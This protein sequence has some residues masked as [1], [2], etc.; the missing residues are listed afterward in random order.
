MRVRGIALASTSFLLG[1]LVVIS[2]PATGAGDPSVVHFTA[3]ADYGSLTQTDSVLDLIN[4]TDPDLNIAVG[5]LSYAA[6]G[7][8]QAWSDRVTSRVG[9]GFPFEL[10]SGN[11]ESNGLNGN[12]NDFSACLPNQLPG[13]IGTYGRQYYVDTPQ[14]APLVRFI[15]LDANLDFADGTHS[16]EPGTARYDWT[17]AA[18]DGARAAGVPGWWWGCTGLVSRWAST[19]ARSVPV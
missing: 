11:H 8:E 5:D 6:T 14:S 9:P 18:I 1:A 12:I 4:T 17:A 19:P 3:A 7:S 2:T 15:M 10:L 13:L 16:Y